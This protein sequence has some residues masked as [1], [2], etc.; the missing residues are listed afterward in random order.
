MPY[1]P[2]KYKWLQIGYKSVFLAKKD[3][4][5][6]LLAQGVTQHFYYG[7]ANWIRTSGLYDVNVAL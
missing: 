4:V 3:A 7:G 1:S 6:N 5:Y 2:K